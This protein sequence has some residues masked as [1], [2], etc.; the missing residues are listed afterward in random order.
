LRAAPFRVPDDIRAVCEAERTDAL[1]GRV[2]RPGCFCLSLCCWA[3]E[4][5]ELGVPCAYRLLTARDQIVISIDAAGFK[6]TR[7]TPTLIPWSAIQSI[8]A[9]RNRSR[10]ANRVAL[11]IE[12]AFKRGLSIRLGANLFHWANLSFGSVFDVG[13]G[14]LEAEADEIAQAAEPYISK[15][16]QAAR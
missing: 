2:E 10:K 12:P 3:S 5:P 7:L 1:D 6:D 9:Y 15:Q 16:I 11:E 8:Y 4:T 13:I 14:T